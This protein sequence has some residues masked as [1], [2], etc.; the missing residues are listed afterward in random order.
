[1]LRCDDLASPPGARSRPS[2]SALR[3]R[4]AD[5]PVVLAPQPLPVA[6]AQARRR[7]AGRWPAALAAGVDG[8]GHGAGGVA[9]PGRR[10][11]PALH[12]ALR[13]RRP[14]WRDA[15]CDGRCRCRPR[16]WRR[17]RA[18]ASCAM[19]QLDRYLRAHRDYATALAGLVAGRLGPQH[20]HRVA[21]ALKPRCARRRRRFALAAALLA[22]WAALGALPLA[23]A[24]AGRSAS[25]KPLPAH[26]AR[27]WLAR[28]HDGAQRAQLPGHARR[29]APA[30][31]CRARA[32][33]TSAKARSPYERI[34]VARRAHA[35]G[36][37]PQRP[38]S[39]RCGRS[40]AWRWSSSAIR[41]QASLRPVIEPRADEHYEVREQGSDRVAGREAQIL[42]L[43]PRDAY[44]FAQRL[45]V[46]SRSG[47]AAARRRAR[48]PR[49][50]VLESSAFS[51]VA[52]GVKPQPETRAAADEAARRL[53]RGAAGAA[54][55]TQLESEG[56][57][58][59]RGGAG[60]PAEQLHA[61]PARRRRTAARR[62]PPVLQA[63]FSDG[64]THVSL[65]IEPFDRAAPHAA[66]AD[67][68]SAP[69]TR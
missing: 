24:G 37:P 3:A 14:P 19:P 44:R 13:R 18:G 2:W 64:L 60:L 56:W 66:A 8:R 33:R 40:R 20:R 27:K 35:A 51:E 43:S 46:D 6:A 61:S 68:R 7:R 32:S 53:P 58:L 11:R 16:R 30:A 47:P 31:R 29:S 28:I 25:A 36:L 67:R 65:F 50:Q 38:W 54:A 1:M 59:Q 21:R 52:I 42:L 17:S 9:G 10:R 55:P 15:R 62:R 69:R 22:L 57:A 12:A 45:W 39:T 48:R 4:L 26:E 63:I 49:Q 41:G 5:E 34:E 23:H